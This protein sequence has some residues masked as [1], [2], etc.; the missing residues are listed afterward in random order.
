[1]PGHIPPVTLRVAPQ[2]IPQ[3]RKAFEESAAE[4]SAF[5]GRA[6]RDGYIPEP[7]LGDAVSQVVQE[8]YNQQ[9]MGSPEGPL[10]AMTAYEAELR[11]AAEQLKHMEEHYRRTEGDNAALWGKA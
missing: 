7:W 1:V 6:S 5:I 4:V 11:R 9:V 10:A 2:A 8:Y 3:L